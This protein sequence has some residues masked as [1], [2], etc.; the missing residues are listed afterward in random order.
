MTGRKKAE[1]VWIGLGS[2]LGDRLANIRKAAKALT[3]LSESR[4]HVASSIFE[5]APLGKGYGGKFYNAVI[6]CV[7]RAIN[8]DP[9][10]EIL[11]H[12]PLLAYFYDLINQPVTNIDD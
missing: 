10:I 5:T 3:V 12:P 1:I 11:L 4:L 2:N 8:H 6:G 7:L 9:N